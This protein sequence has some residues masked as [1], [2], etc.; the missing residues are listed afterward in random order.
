MEERVEEKQ[1]QPNFVQAAIDACNCETASKKQKTGVMFID[2]MVCHH[3]FQ[4]KTEKLKTKASGTR[5]HF[6]VHQSE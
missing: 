4:T 3:F 1:A 5:A 6:T 2:I